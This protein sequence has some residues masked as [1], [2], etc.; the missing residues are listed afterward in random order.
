MLANVLA[1]GWDPFFKGLTIVIIAVAVLAGS[2]YL[3]LGTNLGARL[4]LL[5]ALA[6]LMGWM[7][8]MGAIWAVYGI[9]LK[10]KEPSWKPKEIVVNDLG[11]ARFDAARNPGLTAATNDVTVDGWAKLP[12]DNPGRGQAVAA[13]DEILQIETATLKAGDYLP[14]AVYDKDGGRFPNASFD[15]WKFGTVNLD[16]LAFFHREHF[17]LVEVQPVVKQATEPG[18]APPLPKADP[19][20]PT[21]FVL[22]ERDRGSKRMPAFWITLGSGLLFAILC[23]ILH[24]RDRLV[25]ANQAALPQTVGV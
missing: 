11:Q 1:V 12:D 15:L 23:N 22:M 25:M 5:V 10:G 24:R 20:A 6:G 21:Y 14:L 18:K 4:G 13:A 2:T 17:A 19:D 7:F 9:G 16:Y 8:L 3:L